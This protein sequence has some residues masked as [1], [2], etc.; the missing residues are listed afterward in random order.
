MDGTAMMVG[1]SCSMAI[2]VAPQP[3]IPLFSMQLDGSSD[4]QSDRCF[5][6]L[7]AV[8]SMSLIESIDDFKLLIVNYLLTL[9][10]VC[11]TSHL[12]FVSP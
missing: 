6:S 9:I 7:G 4:I 11:L 2:V 1:R 12:F 3:V 5:A 10:E 8:T